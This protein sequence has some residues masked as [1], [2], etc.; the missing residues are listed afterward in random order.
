MDHGCTAKCH[1]GRVNRIGSR[2]VSIGY[3]AWCTMFELVQVACRAHANLYWHQKGLAVLKYHYHHRFGWVVRLLRV[4]M[5][6]M[7]LE[8]R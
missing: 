4:G 8:D 7:L 6:S 5:I 3:V 2:G 1:A